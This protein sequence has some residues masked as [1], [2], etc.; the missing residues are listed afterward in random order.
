MDNIPIALAF[1]NTLE[2]KEFYST[3]DKDVREDVLKH[4]GEFQSIEEIERYLY[5]L[6]HSDSIH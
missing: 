5:H 4:S 1:L 6:D 2:G 3:L